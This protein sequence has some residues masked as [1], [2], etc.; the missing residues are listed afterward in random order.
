MCPVDFKWAYLH[1]RPH[2]HTGL[3]FFHRDRSVITA[4]TLSQ[5]LLSYLEWSGIKTEGITPHSLRIGAATTGAEQGASE[6]QL[7]LLG[8]WPSGAYNGFIQPGAVEFKLQGNDRATSGGGGLSSRHPA[9]L[10]SASSRCQ[11][12]HPLT[13]HIFVKSDTPASAVYQ[14]T[15][16]G[17]PFF[18]EYLIKS[19]FNALVES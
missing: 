9:N 10:S 5:I 1:I 15:W 12:A 2:L 4:T 19:R 14:L 7:K 8:H 3:L 11:G 6:S 18:L 17:V 16:E 13:S